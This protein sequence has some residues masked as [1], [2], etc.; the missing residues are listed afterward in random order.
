MLTPSAPWKLLCPLPIR[1]TLHHAAA[2]TT[3]A[4]TLLFSIRLGAAIA[5]QRLTDGTWYA[6]CPR[7]DRQVALVALDVVTALPVLNPDTA[8]PTFES[9]ATA[10]L[11]AWQCAIWRQPT[12]RRYSTATAAM[13]AAA[14]RSGR[15]NTDPTSLRNL[16]IASHLRSTAAIRAIAQRLI[17]ANLLDPAARDWSLTLPQRQGH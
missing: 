15:I 1:R 5:P 2:N 3:A 11:A 14:T 17:D 4:G 7:C 12:L 13:A 16:A 9:D 10:F 6:T 8:A